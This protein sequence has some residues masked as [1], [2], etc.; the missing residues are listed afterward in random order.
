MSWIE[1]NSNN[2]SMSDETFEIWLNGQ[3]GKSAKIAGSEQF[4]SILGSLIKTGKY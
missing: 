4:S 1:A 2:S 3:N